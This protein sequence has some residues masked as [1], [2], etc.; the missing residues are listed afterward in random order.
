MMSR[1]AQ[2][3]RALCCGLRPALPLALVVGCS[4]TSWLKPST[5]LTAAPGA[6][7]V[8]AQD[9]EQPTLTPQEAQEIQ[10]LTTTLFD[11]A[12]S[13]ATRLGAARRL[14]ALDRAEALDVLRQAL[15]GGDPL[16][17]MSVIGALNEKDQPTPE[18]LGEVASVLRQAPPDALDP[19]ALLL[20]KYG[21]DGLEAVTA[22][23]QDQN[24]PEA[25]RLGPIHALS[26]F[27]SKRGV[28]GL[29]RLLD[30]DRS[31]PE[32]IVQ[33]SCA[34]LGRLT[35]LPFGPNADR[36]NRWW[37]AAKDLSEEDWLRAL[38]IRLT[39]I[40]AEREQEILE[41]HEQSRT[42]SRRLLE[43]L[44]DLYPF[45][46]REEQINRLPGLLDDELPTVRQFG[47]NRIDVLLRDAVPIPQEVQELLATRLKDPVPE[48]RLGAA[49]LLEE[50]RYPGLGD[51]VATAIETEADPR[52]I[53]RYL[54]VLG[55]NPSPTALGP[56]RR[57]LADDA[58]GD[59]AAA[60]LWRL[61]ET[62]PLPDDS[63]EATRTDVRQ[64][65]AKRASPILAKVLAWIGS[66]QDAT[67]LEPRLTDP[68][69]AFRE[70]VAQGFR[71]R[72]LVQP[73]LDRA[74]DPL[75]FP[76]AVAALAESEPTLGNL[77]HLAEL[78][79]T[80]AQ[81]AAWQQAL[82]TLAGRFPPAEL[83]EVDEVLRQFPQR[84]DAALRAEVLARAADLAPTDLPGEERVALLM[85][86]ADLWLELAQYQGAYR[87]LSGLGAGDA[88][89]ALEELRFRAAA[90]AGEYD[91]AALHAPEPGPWV[92]VLEAFAERSPAAAAALRDEISRRFA[93]QLTGEIRVRFDAVS[94]RVADALAPSE[95]AGDGDDD[96][97]SPG[98]LPPDLD[99]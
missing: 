59:D 5:V 55:S 54:Q 36:W 9:E 64:A 44:R 48:M 60:G 68:N 61:R 45:L 3:L 35:G 86:L 13:P 95:P 63:L 76:H 24:L 31:E 21:G 38:V 20:V 56:I 74:E 73:L 29:L 53:Q 50:L 97:G 19:I 72:E 30:P 52:V 17:M 15:E 26:W 92:A 8:A 2:I 85:R 47:I 58:L 7:P 51:L 81:A 82:R 84:I 65:L 77:R 62:G 98:A 94:Q 49:S 69:P 87:L 12:A 18:L 46:S 32:A 23:A 88:N 43:T 37:D 80:E 16:V 1:P 91:A 28:A 33:A 83:L 40:I 42:I 34:A 66:E 25:E 89:A 39:E 14:L 67:D 57:W 10:W 99:E 79:P 75:V 71:A 96:G 27:R 22:L 70:A 41:G 11:A 78:R 93:E 4:D 90:M 6:L